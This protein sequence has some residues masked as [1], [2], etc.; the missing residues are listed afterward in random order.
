ME[1]RMDEKSGFSIFDS[2][3][4]VLLVV[5]LGSGVWRLMHDD[6]AGIAR[7]AIA[8]LRDDSKAATFRK[9]DAPAFARA[10]PWADAAHAQE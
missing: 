9:L 10:W 6:T 1:A 2:A 5:V 4:I 8:A 7:T 3:V